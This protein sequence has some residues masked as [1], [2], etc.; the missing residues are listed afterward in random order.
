MMIDFFCQRS[1]LVGE[2][3]RRLEIFE[4]EFFLKVMVIYDY[5]SVAQLI[6]K[7]YEFRALQRFNTL[8][9]RGGQFSTC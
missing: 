6:L 2:I 4:L 5:P 7:L 8:T 3:K 1:D 9:S